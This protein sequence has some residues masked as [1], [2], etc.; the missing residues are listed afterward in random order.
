[1]EK[2]FL[3]KKIIKKGKTISFWKSC[4]DGVFHKFSVSYYNNENIYYLDGLKVTAKVFHEKMGE[5]IPE[6]IVGGVSEK[7][8]RDNIKKPYFIAIFERQKTELN[9]LFFQRI[10][11]PPVTFNISN[12]DSHPSVIISFAFYSDYGAEIYFAD[13]QYH[14]EKW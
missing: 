14:L 1:M 3:Y 10:Y 6:Y 12:V 4:S 7:C 2:L 8:L 13:G 5:T 9:R 11:V